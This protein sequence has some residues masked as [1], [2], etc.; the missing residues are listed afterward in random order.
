[1]DKRTANTE[2]STKEIHTGAILPIDFLT[3]NIP[4]NQYF[5][6]K[7]MTGVLVPSQG[8]DSV[9]IAD[10]RRKHDFFEVGNIDAATRKCIQDELIEPARKNLDSLI[11]NFTAKIQDIQFLNGVCYRDPLRGNFLRYLKKIYNDHLTLLNLKKINDADQ[12]LLEQS[13]DICSLAT[14][15]AIRSDVSSED[16]DLICKGALLINI[17]QTQVTSSGASNHVDMGC[18]YLETLGYD[19]T[20]INIVRFKSSFEKVLPEPRHVIG[21]VKASYLYQMSQDK[22]SPGK[23]DDYSDCHDATMLKL[24]TYVRLKY[25]NARVYHLMLRV[26][27]ES[28]M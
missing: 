10:I 14:I 12:N 5:K 6:T 18:Q 23:T 9:D 11:Q 16:V 20:I 13:M 24:K 28:K 3:E 1:M 22:F 19:P 8:G 27:N 26:F 15:L 21:I 25:L 2:D 7:S 17:G 4:V